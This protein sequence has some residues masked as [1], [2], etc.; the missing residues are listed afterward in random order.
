MIGYFSQDVPLGVGGSALWDRIDAHI[1]QPVR[2]SPIGRNSMA[3]PPFHRT[4]YE[5]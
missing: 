2:V 4:L 5:K 1:Y 3:C